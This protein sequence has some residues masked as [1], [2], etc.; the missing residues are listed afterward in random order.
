MSPTFAPG[1][2][3]SSKQTHKK[4]GPRREAGPEVLM[5][6]TTRTLETPGTLEASSNAPPMYF[7]SS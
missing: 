3:L 7:H 4:T 6:I 5:L 2:R 1:W